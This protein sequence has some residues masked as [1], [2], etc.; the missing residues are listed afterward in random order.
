MNRQ[1]ILSRLA[2][3]HRVVYSQGLVRPSWIVGRKRRERLWSLFGRM[4]RSDNVWVDVPAV[5]FPEVDGFGMLGR[6]LM[7]WGLWN[8]RRRA[9]KAWNGRARALV[10]YVFAPRFADYIE[11]LKPTITV[12]HAYDCFEKQTGWSEA[13]ARKHERMLAEADVVIAS[14][15]PIGEW[16]RKGGAREVHVVPNGVDFDLFRPPERVSE[17]DLPEDLREIPRPRIGYFG[18]INRKVDLDLICRLS[19]RRPDWQ[20]V[21]VGGIRNLDEATRGALERCRIRKNVLFLGQKPHREVPRYL[22]GMDAA[23]AAYRMDGGMWTALGYPLKLHE[24]LAAGKP[25]V[26]SPLKTVLPFRNVVAVAGN[27]DEWEGAIE[28]ALVHGGQGSPEER[29]RV[30]RENTW[31]SRVERIESLILE[32]VERKRGGRT[33]S[34]PG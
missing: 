29:M 16:L 32:A 14:S 33:S 13:I 17:Q 2:R 27:V 15:E 18:N 8:L 22:W 21:L 7:R 10:A 23:I 26:S 6:G 4:E 28:H 25:V 1:H 34:S 19:E 31:D 9:E 30:A 5:I 24:Y 12:Y 3:T 11:H 20:F